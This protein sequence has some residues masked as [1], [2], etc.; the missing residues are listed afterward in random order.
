MI[1]KEKA[2]LFYSNL[3]RQFINIQGGPKVTSQRFELIARPLI[4]GSKK[5]V[6]ECAGT[7]TGWRNI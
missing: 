1:I 5:F 3:Y 2:I 4:I 7:V 6:P